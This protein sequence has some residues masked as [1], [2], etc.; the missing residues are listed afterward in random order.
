MTAG[1]VAITGASGFLGSHLVDAALEAGLPVRG[2]VRRP[3]ALHRAVPAARA[4]LADEAALTRAFEGASAVIANAALGSWQG[5]LSRYL[6]VNVDG[7]GRTL[8]AAAAAGVRRVV[9]ISTVAVHRT[10]LWGAVDEGS[11][12]V[13]DARPWANPSDLTTDWRYALSKARG[14]ALAWR[15]AE[16]LGLD[17]T[18]LRPG[19]VYGPRDP[20]L[21]P[22]MCRRAAAPVV[23][24]PTLAIPFV[25]AADVARAAV[26]ALSRPQSRGR[27]FLLAGPP[28]P[29]SQLLAH[30]RRAQGGAGLLLP[31][32][33]PLAVRYDTR[34][35]AQV[36]GFAPRPWTEGWVDA[37]A[38]L[39][40][41][42]LPG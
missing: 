6:E 31:V 21:T 27:A 42:T 33:L 4:D 26:A 10:R 18:A 13:G 24:A 37:A 15:L 22:A 39:P 40:G 41:P 25:H 17:L 38:T 16:E 8:R 5:P 7:L 29:L 28:V 20:K 11:P 19:P 12:L 14:E 1:P 3:E 36:L 9:L 30:L 34:A 32:P 23:W 35:A 2:V